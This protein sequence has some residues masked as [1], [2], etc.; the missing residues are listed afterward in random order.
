MDREMRGEVRLRYS[1]FILFLSRLISVGTGLLFVLI[2]T[3]NISPDEFGL[4]GNL[5]DT[6][7]YFTLAATI[8]PF[9]T[10]RFSARKHPGTSRTGL[11]AN[12]FLSAIFSLLYLSL[13]STI[14]TMLKIGEAYRIVYAFLTFQIIEA[15][16]ISELEAILLAE[17]PHSMG[18]GFLIYE[19][20]KVAAA[21]FLIME[22]RLGLLG[23]VCSVIFAYTVQIAF[24]LKLAAH[25][26]GD[27]IKW[28]YVKEW[29]KASP[30]NLYN[31]AGQRLASFVLILLFVYGGELARAYY[32][33][34][35]TIATV[36]SYSSFLAY[37]LYPRLLSRSSPEDV[38]VSLR[39]VLMFTMPMTVGAIILS[40]SYLTI[41]NPVYRD[42][43][44]ILLF[45]SMNNASS[46]LT[47]VFSSIVMGSE[48]LDAEGKIVFKGL[49]KSGFFL[50]YSLPFIQ[51]AFM[52]PVTYFTL[53]TMVKGGIEA[54]TAVSLIILIANTAILFVV[55]AIARKYIRF[56]IP[57]NSLTK[58]VFASTV[59][60]V[61]LYLFPSPTRLTATLALTLLGAV[62][63][64]AVL[65]AIDRETRAIVRS[66]KRTLP[67]LFGTKT[68]T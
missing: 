16:A 60:A 19:A 22:L 61:T 15:Y 2:V 58:Y 7:G 28:G 12:L 56:G 51:S 4:F 32:G 68:E 25:N 1:G 47:Y 40:D 29:I 37:A 67:S 14:I 65:S 30:I 20:S 45:L 6:L 64:F 34:A 11:I 36:I 5:G 13:L 49:V 23:A 44:L 43:R 3:R 54:A 41:L 31:I 57:W 17:Q 62:V 10:T 63:Y 52:L 39:M 8:V 53:T 9:W 50:V 18:F 46:N 38:S 59:M 48:K 42:A 33:A 66:A 26:L 55:Y 21:F 35:S 24:Y 27:E